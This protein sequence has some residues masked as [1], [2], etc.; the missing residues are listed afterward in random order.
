MVRVDHGVGLHHRRVDDVRGTVRGD[1]LMNAGQA[2][3]AAM[4]EQKRKDRPRVLRQWLF[5]TPPRSAVLGLLDDR[6]RHK[7]IREE[8][9]P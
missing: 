8:W 1:T 3:T 5:G 4:Q 6:Y 2:V 9:N 7:L